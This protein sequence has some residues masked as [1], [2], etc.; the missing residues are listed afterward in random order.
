MEE[1]KVCNKCGE[2][3]PLSLFYKSK[4]KGTS[5][6]CKKCM[7]ENRKVNKS[8]TPEQR[9]A[10]KLAKKESIKQKNEYLRSLPTKVCKICEIEKSRS[11]FSKRGSAADGLRSEC[12]ICCSE[13][14]A[15]LRKELREKAKYV[16][17]E[18]YLSQLKVCAGCGKEKQYRE[19]KLENK[20]VPSYKCLDCLKVD[21]KEY[22]TINKEKEAVVNKQYRQTNPE[23]LREIYR[24]YRINNI[25]Y[26]RTKSRNRYAWRI[27]SIDQHT[28]EDVFRLYEEQNGVCRYCSEP[29][30]NDYHVDHIF[31][32]SIYKY[33]GPLDLQLLCEGCNVSK[34]NKDPIMYER[35]RGILT[36]ERELFLLQ[37]KEFILER[38]KEAA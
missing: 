22:Y 1:T 4:Y 14:D 30:G 16:V 7:D 31:P 6:Y 18:N 2:V 29:L 27:Q 19:F 13:Y 37:L 3:K 38:T 34:L 32:L 10:D 23:K 25:E 21:R 15:K 17:D 5:Y 8:K 20:L 24:N 12:K 36:D 9:E 35:K 33:N 26:C 28:V 11:E